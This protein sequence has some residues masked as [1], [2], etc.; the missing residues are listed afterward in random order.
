MVW[1]V[2][3]LHIQIVSKGSGKSCA[4][5]EAGRCHLTTL[6]ARGTTLIFQV[7]NNEDTIKKKRITIVSHVEVENYRF[8][9]PDR[10]FANRFFSWFLH[11][12][13]LA[14]NSLAASVD[15]MLLANRWAHS[16]AHFCDDQHL[17][18]GI[19]NHIFT[20]FIQQQ[21]MMVFTILLLRDSFFCKVSYSTCTMI[22][23]FY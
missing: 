14:W 9:S 18:R 15:D 1:T 7:L 3:S 5:T 4:N 6:V 11:L 17:T 20:I 19:R 2:Q 12:R 10:A 8:R 13:S 23:E 21:L 22:N 16:S